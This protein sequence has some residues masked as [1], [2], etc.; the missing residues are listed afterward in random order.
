M[1]EDHINDGDYVVI[2][3][4]ETASDG[5]IV[6]ALWTMEWQPLREFLKKPHEYAFNR[7]TP[8]CSQYSLKTSEFKAKS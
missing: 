7:Q 1:I 5:E 2:E 4:T 6:V 8:Q 3:Q